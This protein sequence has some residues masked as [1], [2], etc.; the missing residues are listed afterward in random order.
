[1]TAKKEPE[2]TVPSGDEPGV[3]LD[4]S[5]LA[6]LYVPEAESDL[7]DEFLRGRRDIM[8]SELSITEV[9][10]AVSRLKREGLLNPGNANQIKDALLADAK[11]FRRLELSPV[12]HR[13]AERLLLSTEK[14]SLRTLD[15]LHIALALSA[16][17]A[18]IVTFDA[19]MA[20]AAMQH[21]LGVVEL[22]SSAASSQSDG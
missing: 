7:L 8:V 5:A 6:K 13:Q 14:T 1:M 2:A 12:L 19:R 9:I 18:R 17:A 4:S 15:A 11:F 22:Q 21:G 20:A 16:G 3:Y 10:S